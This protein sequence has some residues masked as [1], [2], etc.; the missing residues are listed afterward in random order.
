M[1]TQ[2]YSPRDQD[3]YLIQDLPIGA[4]IACVKFYA[5]PDLWAPGLSG[6]P[7][8]FFRRVLEYGHY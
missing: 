8:I 5:A 6:G 7:G 4:N 3:S 2:V 1:C